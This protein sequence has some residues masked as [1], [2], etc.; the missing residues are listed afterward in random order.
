MKQ[1]KEATAIAFREFRAKQP[2]LAQDIEYA[3]LLDAVIQS[4]NSDP[5]ALAALDEASAAKSRPGTIHQLAQIVKEKLP[6]VL[7]RLGV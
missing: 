1:V 2:E 3:A 4:I 6:A 7:C 5:K